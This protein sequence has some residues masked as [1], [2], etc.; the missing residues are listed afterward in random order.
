M[1]RFLMVDDEEIVRRGFETK[2]DWAGQGFEFLPPCENGRDAIA[3][4]EELRPDVVMTD[5]HMPHADGISVAAHAME[6]HPDIVV[7]ILSGYDEFGYAQA[8]IRNK[9]FDYVLKPVSSRELSALL[10]KIKA[11]LDSD[12]RSRADET[13]LK[14]LADLSG[15]LLRERGLAE[16]VSGAR[17]ALGAAEAETVFG[18]DP[19]TLACAAVVA[20][21]SGEPSRTGDMRELMAASLRQARRSA[22]FFPAEGRGAALV[23]EPGS[24]R[25]RATAA[26][27]ATA[28]LDGGGGALRI[29]VSRAFAAWI[30]APRAYSEAAAALAYRLVRSPAEPYFY[31]QGSEDREA[32]ADLRAKEERLCLGV[33][34]GAGGRVPELAMSYVQALASADL[35]PQRV[36]HEVLALFSRARDELAGIGV[37]AAS[38]SSKLACDYYRYAEGLD[39]PEA[40]TTALVR[41]AEV[42][43]GSLE[44]NGLHEPEWKVLDFREFVA[45]HYADKGLSIGKAAERLSISE[46]YLSKLLR[47]RLGTSF[48]EYLSDYRIDRAK[49]L[50][51]SSDMLTYEV[52]EAVGYPDAR[53]FASLFKKRT[54]MT[55]SDYRKSLGATAER[56]GPADPGGEG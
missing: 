52:A 53:Y 48:V 12:R 5:I 11:K 29:G 2:I 6:R 50:M 20:E 56:G 16:F 8:A 47:R 35:S 3:A 44:A 32:L 23:F 9:V 4:I 38:L 7:V 14:E 27:V 31:V 15:D 19:G 22:S 51:A 10:A 26:S 46:S 13:V 54:G 40:V 1:Y 34:T 45:R 41:L 49:E 30:D 17:G 33:R 42:A 25:C 37:S 43:A 39:S 28:I 24:E 21:R 55:P 18:F 36:R